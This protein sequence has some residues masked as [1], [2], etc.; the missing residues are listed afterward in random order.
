MFKNREDAA[1]Q[2]VNKLGAYANLRP[3]VLAIP[4]GAVPMGKIIAEALNGELDV[5][6]VRK[7]RSPDSAEFAIGAIDEAG[8]TYIDDHAR[9][10]YDGHSPANQA[11]LAA[12]RNTQLALLRQ[13]RQQLAGVRPPLSP[14]GRVV[15]VVD[16]GLATGSTMIAALKTLRLQAPHS[17]ICAVPA[18][19]KDTLERVRPYADKV[20][21][22]TTP[23]PF[24]AV[25]N[26]YQSFPQ[27]TDEEV[28]A[29]LGAQLA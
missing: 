13:R 16:D 6:L 28:L 25:G 10:D 9:R 24:Y 8:R 19:P 17:L 23:N 5:V 26:C 2:L 27:V 15:I 14:R 11:W 20:V 7:L 1:R 29:L 12:E 4:R 18:A 21:C 22:L 3:L